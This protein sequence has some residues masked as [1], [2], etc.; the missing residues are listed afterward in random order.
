MST[1]FAV[2]LVM[3]GTAGVMAIILFF[4]FRVVVLWYFR[5]N[6]IADN[7]AVIADHYR[8]LGQAPGR[9][10]TPRVPPPPRPNPLV[11]R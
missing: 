8:Q 11:S 10:L 1:D 4:V 9:P 7:I 3:L 5:L 6:Q 2:G